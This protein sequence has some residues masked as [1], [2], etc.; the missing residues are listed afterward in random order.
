MEF[1]GIG[2]VANAGKFDF[3]PSLKKVIKK[4]MLVFAVPQT[5]FGR[6]DPYVYESA[7]R[8][9][10]TGVI[11][12]KDMLPETAFVKLGWVLGHREWRGKAVTPKMMLEN[13]AGEFNERLGNEFL[14]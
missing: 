8:I 10:E 4:G 11:Y 1:A 9:S 6:L 12:L 13:F 7:R 3:I 2:Q 5:L 14:K